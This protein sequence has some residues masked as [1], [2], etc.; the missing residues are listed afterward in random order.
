[1]YSLSSAIDAFPDVKVLIIGDLMLDRFTYGKIERISPEA[2]VPIFKVVSQKEM[3]GGAGNVATNL[4]ALGC[5]VS[6]VGLVGNDAEGSTLVNL[7][8]GSGVRTHL[9]RPENFP[10]IVKNRLIAGSNHISRVDREGT[11]PDLSENLPFFLRAFRRLAKQADIVLLSD[12]GKGLF[13]ADNTPQLIEICREL[14]KRVIVDPKGTDYS[15][16]T[17][18]TL[19]KPNLK[20]FTEVASR[21]LFDPKAPDFHERL[22]IAA[23]ELIDRY[24]IGNLLITLGEHGMALVSAEEPTRVRQIPTRAKEVFDVSGAGDTS[25]ATLGAALACNAPLPQAMHLANLA[26]GIVVGKVGTATVSADELRDALRADD[27]GSVSSR[28]PER[29]I[30]SLPQAENFIAELRR[31]GKIIG[32]TNGVFDCCHMGHL[33]S[34]LEASKTCDALVVAVNSDASVRRLKGEGRPLQDEATRSLLLASLEYVSCVIIF[35]EDTPM[36]VVK[37]L[38]P[39]VL[40]KEGYTIDR[41][42]EAQYARQYGAKIVTLQRIGNYSTTNMIDRI[43]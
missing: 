9:V 7:L 28:S 21:G 34:L 1:M 6:Y 43:R 33:S 24:H 31:K 32:F 15:K 20:E 42:P 30:M 17:G 5:R 14:G 26:S 11:V 39:D 4:R 2:P 36:E 23:T 18:A 12:Y 40:A 38:R 22:R 8:K 13:T 10:T 25:L 37:A 16:Y 35:E 41:W 3:P 19:V 27:R 29:K